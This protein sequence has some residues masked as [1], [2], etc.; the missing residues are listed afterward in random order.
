MNQVYSIAKQ[1]TVTGMSSK[2]EGFIHGSW[3]FEQML[4]ALIRDGETEKLRAFLEES[5]QTEPYNEG[6]LAEDPLRQ[7]KNIFIGLVTMV[8]KTAAVPGGLDVEEA[9]RLIDL[10]VQECEKTATVEAVRSLEWNM[11]FDFTERV[12][13]SKRPDYLSKEVAMSMDHIQSNTNRNLSVDDIAA[14]VGK[15]RAW[16]TRAFRREL[17]QSV[18]QYI[19]ACKISDAKRLLRHSDMSQSQISSYLGFS[20]QSYFQAVFK[21]ATGATP[22]AYRE[23]RAV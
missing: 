15:S 1:H 14:H 3:L 19:T 4:Y 7:S 22:K 18:G 9:Y 21:K 5:K 12:A 17:G 23:Y 16:L 11:V 10:Y 13:M 2:E 8:G 6:K 20:S